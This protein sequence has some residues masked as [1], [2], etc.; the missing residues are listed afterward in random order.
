MKLIKDTTVKEYLKHVIFGADQK[1]DGWV[2]AMPAAEEEEP[3]LEQVI[4]YC[5]Q[6][7]IHLVEADIYNEMKACF[8]RNPKKGEWVW[9]PDGM[10]F[11]IGAWVCGHC[12]AKPNSYWQGMRDINPL[13]F[14]G[15]RYCPNCGIKMVGVIR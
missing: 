5:H 15:S 8:G 3:T 7:C 4:R 1:I 2:D 14:S 13:R 6:R 9:N 11:G 10:D 12:R